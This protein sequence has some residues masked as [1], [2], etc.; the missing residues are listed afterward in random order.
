MTVRFFS[1]FAAALLLTSAAFAQ[2]A[3]PA[4]ADKPAAAAVNSAAAPAVT[5]A[6][7]DTAKDYRI[8]P[9]DVLDIWV[10]G[11]EDLSRRIPVLPDGKI[12]MPYVN[13]VMAAGKTTAELRDIIK[14]GLTQHEIL[15][16]PVV[17]VMV[18]E[19]RSARG[20]VTGSVRMPNSYD[21]RT[22]ATVMEM[23]GKGQGFTEWANKD[24]ITL[25]RAT[26]GERVKMKWGRLVDGKD[27]NLVMLAGDIL[28]VGGRD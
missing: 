6:V 27:P 16:N 9:E 24:D 13:D 14:Q 1:I 8:G 19:V 7:G 17:S 28:V 5:P 12:S 22:G 23:I 10:F 25:I 15:K 11:Q 2:D 4:P 20:T 3:G 26:N 18:Y 21:L